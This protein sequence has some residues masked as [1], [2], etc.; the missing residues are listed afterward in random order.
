MQVFDSSKSIVENV[1]YLSGILILI[2]IVVGIIQLI[3]T[4]KALVVTSKREAANLA[5]KK[6]DDYVMRI[7]PL[8]DKLFYKENELKMEKPKV[9][10]SK[11]NQSTLKK[12]IGE[13]EYIKIFKERLK[14][15]S[16]VLAILNALEAFSVYFVKNVADE[17]IAYSCIG[18]TFVHTVDSLCFDVCA[19]IKDDD[20]MSF[21]N[22]IKL[23]EIWSN[24]IKK[25]KL[26]KDHQAVLSQLQRIPDVVLKPIG[27]K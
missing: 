15:M 1:Y 13:T 23:Y 25:E 21:Q 8:I 16:Y 22:M 7:I 2:S 18:I 26:R 9:E 19:C 6:V 11:F 4:K 10:L 3:L 14:V 5:A 27:T 24:R 20:D 17:E 12:E